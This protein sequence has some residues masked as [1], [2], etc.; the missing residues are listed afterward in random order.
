MTLS[1]GFVIVSAL[2][3]RSSLVNEARITKIFPYKSNLISCTSIGTI[4]SFS[5]RE[6]VQVL[7]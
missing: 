1:Y 6:N 3:V 5:Q 4:K 7:F 2:I